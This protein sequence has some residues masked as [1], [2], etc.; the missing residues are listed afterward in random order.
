MPKL[1]IKPFGYSSGKVY[2]LEQARH[3]NFKEIVLVD[4]R[5]VLSYDDLVQL[6]SQD[7]YKNQEQIEIVLLP[8]I[9]GG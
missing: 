4:G 2:E 5:R 8:A 7:N 6:V 1:L 9:A 3:L